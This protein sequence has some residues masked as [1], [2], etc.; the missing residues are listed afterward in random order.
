M[1]FNSSQPGIL[2]ACGA[3]KLVVNE[4]GSDCL[5]KTFNNPG[6]SFFITSFCLFEALGVLKRK[7]SREKKIT[8]D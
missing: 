5:L 6:G 7:W 4:D 3:V 2:D 1:T 8:R